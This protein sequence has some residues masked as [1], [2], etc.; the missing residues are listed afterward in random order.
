V[1]CCGDL[2]DYGPESNFVIDWVR[3][4]A[5]AVVRGNHDRICSGLDSVDSFNELAQASA[6]WTTEQLT[7]PNRTYL[8]E[9]PRGP[10][11]VDDC[12]L[13]V[14]GSPRHEDEYVIGMEEVSG[15]FS[16]LEGSEVARLPVFFGHT[17]WQGVFLRARGHIRGVSGPLI[18]TR[19]AQIGLEAG[20][21]Y[22]INPGA[23]GQPRDGDPRAA[24]AIFDSTAREVALR[25]VTYDHEATERKIVAAG[26][27]L[28]LGARLAFG[29]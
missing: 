5:A 27:P 6:R 13:L 18:P 25:R 9:L 2:C 17:H 10:M 3:A 26:L 24:Y 20:A 8:R 22:L 28:R 19:E 11:V 16:F 23:V 15:V 21:A 12:L 7:P 14:H 29:H 4:H 1:I